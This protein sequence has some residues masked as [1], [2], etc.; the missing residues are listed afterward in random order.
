MTKSKELI[1]LITTYRITLY[2][3]SKERSTTKGIFSFLGEIFQNSCIR[4]TWDKKPVQNI[5]CVILK[6]TEK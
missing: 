2:Q 5:P 1:L 6:T 3:G 4:K